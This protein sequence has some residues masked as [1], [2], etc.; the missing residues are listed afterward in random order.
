[1][2][3]RQPNKRDAGAHYDQ[4]TRDRLGERLLSLMAIQIFRNGAIHGDPNPGNFAVREDGTLVMYDYGCVKR[5]PRELV[6]AYRDLFKPR[7]RSVSPP[8]AGPG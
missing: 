5:L 7:D 8:R 1:M 2:S 6:F 4:A 3:S